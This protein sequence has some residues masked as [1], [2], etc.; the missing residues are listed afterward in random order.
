MTAYQIMNDHAKRKTWGRTAW[1]CY[2]AICPVTDRADWWESWVI[3]E[4]TLDA[5]G[6]VEEA[7]KGSRR[8]KSQK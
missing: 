6:F 8:I 2:L 5:W 4:D 7:M 1:D 3:F